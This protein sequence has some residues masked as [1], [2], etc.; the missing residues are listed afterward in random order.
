MVPP[1]ERPLEDEAEPVWI[2][3]AVPVD[4]LEVEELVDEVA[5]VSS[6]VDVEVT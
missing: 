5:E 4:E 6:A 3:T 2:A 1:G